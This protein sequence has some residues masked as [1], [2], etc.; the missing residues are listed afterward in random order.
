MEGL[1]LGCLTSFSGWQG[2]G[3]LRLAF[4]SGPFS[5][6]PLLHVCLLCLEF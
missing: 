3:A 4:L 1:L 5:C 6:I 2:T